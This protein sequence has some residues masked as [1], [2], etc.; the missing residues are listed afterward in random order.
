MGETPR[1]RDITIEFDCQFRVHLQCSDFSSIM[2]AFLILLPQ[3]LEDF[4]QK[5][6]VGFAEYE[7]ALEH[8]SFPCKCC[9]NDTDFIWCA[10]R[11]GVAGVCTRRPQ[12]FYF[13]SP[14]DGK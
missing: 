1:K 13:A 12:W 2:K 5:V 6:L 8:K 14:G 9:G 10:G 11:I 3:L 4:F 7:M